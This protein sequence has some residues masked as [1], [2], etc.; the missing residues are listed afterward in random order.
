MSVNF[1]QADRHLLQGTGLGKSARETR[2]RKQMETEP[3]G[4][5]GN[6]LRET[7]KKLR[8]QAADELW[9]TVP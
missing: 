8:N 2:E 9:E 4:R 1:G 5:R 7:Q 3:L 6:S